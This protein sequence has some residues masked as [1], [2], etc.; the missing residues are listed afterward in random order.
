MIS[1]QVS[2]KHYGS[3][4]PDCDLEYAIDESLQTIVVTLT[5]FDSAL[6]SSFIE[7]LERRHGIRAYADDNEAWTPKRPDWQLVVSIQNVP[8]KA[9]VARLIDLPGQPRGA[10]GVALFPARARIDEIALLDTVAL[11]AA[12]AGLQ[13]GQVGTVVELLAEEIFLVEFA[14]YSGKELATIPLRAAQIL[15]ITK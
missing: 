12:H 4:L 11:L 3:S 8:Y 14:D 6:F 5:N 10:L 13:R 7:H 1:N 15:K 2:F 9:K